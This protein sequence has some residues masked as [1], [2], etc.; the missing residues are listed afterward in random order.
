MSAWFVGY[1]PQLSTSV[2]LFRSDPN[3]PKKE[4]ISMKG[5]GNIP[6]LH[7]GDIPAEIWVKYMKEALNGVPET[8]FPE[9]DKL[10]VVADASG[11]PTPSPSIAPSMSP[12]PSPSPSMEPSPSPSPSKGGKPSCK[13]WEICDPGASPS[14]TV[15]P[16]PSPSKTGGG[17]PG[18][19]TNGGGT[20]G[21][22]IGGHGRLIPPPRSRAVE[23]RRTKCDGPLP[24]PAPYGRM[25]A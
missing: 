25:C 13:P 7:G 11:A 2:T 12:S 20:G 23:G 4:L 21:F 6:S 19:A 16:S 9:P 1:T 22:P 14:A 15:S 3:A 18:G 10:G 17:R 24:C 8:E 5:V